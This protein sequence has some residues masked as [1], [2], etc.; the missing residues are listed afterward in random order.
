M[1]QRRQQNQTA[2]L[3]L[4]DSKAWTDGSMLRATPL[5]FKS[6]A[7][8]LGTWLGVFLPSPSP[9]HSLV[10]TLAVQESS[11]LSRLPHCSQSVYLGNLNGSSGACEGKCVHL[12]TCTNII[13]TARECFQLL[14]IDCAMVS[15][16]ARGL[17]VYRTFSCLASFDS[18]WVW[19]LFSGTTSKLGAWGRGVFC[20]L[21]P[22]PGT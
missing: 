8:S 4:G 9:C 16:H 3:S 17:T 19:Y 10:C 15:R 14:H 21:V 1:S 22:S 11:L 20:A 13:T 7:T 5:Y 6:V 12:G 2:G 18:H